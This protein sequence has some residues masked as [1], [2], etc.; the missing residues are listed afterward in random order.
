MLKTPQLHVSSS[1]RLFMEI[2]KK[3]IKSRNSAILPNFLHVITN[4][5]GCRV[6]RIGVE[7]KVGQVI[8]CRGQPLGR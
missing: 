3:E 8:S 5:C 6:R 1:Q 4:L 7:V 2:K